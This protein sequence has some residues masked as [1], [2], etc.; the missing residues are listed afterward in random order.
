MWKLGVKFILSIIV[1]AFGG[2]AILGSIAELGGLAALAIYIEVGFFSVVM[3][4]VCVQKPWPVG[5]LIFGMLCLMILYLLNA[6]AR[7]GI[8]AGAT[9][10][11]DG[12]H[13]LLLLVSVVLSAAVG[14]WL[15]AVFS[16][17]TNETPLL[18]VILIT[19]LMIYPSVCNSIN[20]INVAADRIVTG[21]T[22]ANV[23]QTRTEERIF[24]AGRSTT[25]EYI[26][27]VTVAENALI[28]EEKELKVEQE[29][30]SHLQPGDQVE[31]IL[32]PGAL[33]MPWIEVASTQ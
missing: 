22:V 23:T 6:T 29:L 9:L 16:G 15:L 10:L 4:V 8:L 32:H 13:L 25:F 17:P 28:A 1:V 5:V 2:P 33:G 20:A 14:A 30:Y 27:Y 18:P 26:R 3:L 31:I 11:Q 19:V 12:T 24:S 21:V 7:L